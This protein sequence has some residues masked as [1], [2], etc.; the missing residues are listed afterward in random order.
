MVFLIPPDMW[1]SGSDFDC[2]NKGSMT[3]G[4]EWALS[5]SLNQAAFIHRFVWAVG[6]LAPGPDKGSECN[7]LV[8]GKKA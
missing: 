2:L 1:P 8:C 5:I 7:G 3:C 6:T 4:L